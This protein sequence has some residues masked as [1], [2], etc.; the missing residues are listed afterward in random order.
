MNHHKVNVNYELLGHIA[1][2]NYA[3]VR[4][5]CI[6]LLEM[7]VTKTLTCLGTLKM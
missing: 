1:F 4:F 6:M 3:I 5:I 2:S 7:I